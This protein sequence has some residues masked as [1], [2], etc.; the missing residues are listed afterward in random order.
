MTLNLHPAA[1]AS[2]TK[3]HAMVAS[4][5]LAHLAAHRLPCADDATRGADD[6]ER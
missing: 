2:L 3:W 6:S 5:D 1:A 4:K